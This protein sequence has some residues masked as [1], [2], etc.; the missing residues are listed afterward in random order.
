MMCLSLYIRSIRMHHSCMCDTITRFRITWEKQIWGQR[1]RGYEAQSISE[2][3]MTACFIQLHAH[4]YTS[5]TI[6]LL[7]NSIDSIGLRGSD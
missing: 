3:A 4:I 5:V 2:R 6:H 7:Q 1:E